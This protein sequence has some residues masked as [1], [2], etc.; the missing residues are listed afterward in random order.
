MLQESVYQ[1]LCKT[2]IRWGNGVREIDDFDIVLF[3]IYE[4][5][6]ADNLSK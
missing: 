5:N 3:R 2:L 4:Y 1:Q 6:F